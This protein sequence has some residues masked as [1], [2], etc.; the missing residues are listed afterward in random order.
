MIL[1]FMGLNRNIME[2]KWHFPFEI[3]YFCNRAGKEEKCCLNKCLLLHLF[4]K[5]LNILYVIKLP[6]KKHF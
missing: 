6:R 1:F 3:D 5:V 2:E 4:Q